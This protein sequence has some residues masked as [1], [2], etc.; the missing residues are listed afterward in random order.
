VGLD[1]IIF[2]Q[3]R[4][5][6]VCANVTPASL[7]VLYGGVGGTGTSAACNDP[8][9]VQAVNDLVLCLSLPGAADLHLLRRDDVSGTSDA[10]NSLTGIKNYCNNGSAAYG[11]SSGP[12][13]GANLDNDPIRKNCITQLT[14][15]ERPID[16]ASGA[17]CPKGTHGLVIAL[18]E[19][20]DLASGCPISVSA[21]IGTRISVRSGS[22]D[23]LGVSGLEATKQAKAFLVN[24]IG[25]TLASIRG[26]S[27]PLA[28]PLMINSKEDNALV[29]YEQEFY[30]RVTA[31]KSLTGDTYSDGSTPSGYTPNFGRCYTDRYLNKY[32]FISCVRDCQLDISA[33]SGNLCEDGLSKARLDTIVGRDC[34]ETGGS[35]SATLACCTG[36]ACGADGK[37]PAGPAVGASCTAHNKCDSG[38]CSSGTCA[39]RAA[40]ESCVMDRNCASG[41][42]CTVKCGSGQACKLGVCGT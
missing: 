41:L 24:K 3:A 2:A 39:T 22:R 27:Y 25:P 18:S 26:G 33:N 10:L 6:S 14:S 16:S 38:F 40:G 42:T 17:A 15:C 34:A 13:N 19:A 7:Q 28:R 36:V 35:C 30:H 37:C 11:A 29:N 5:S 31:K 1:G 9:R 12:S 4:S 8:A 32:G 21:T 20:D 23:M